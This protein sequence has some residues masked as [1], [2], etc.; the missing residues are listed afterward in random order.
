MK[1]RIQASESVCRV[2]VELWY[3]NGC[4]FIHRLLAFITSAF[5][6]RPG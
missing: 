2:D 3:K 4:V 6:I 1:A 5:R